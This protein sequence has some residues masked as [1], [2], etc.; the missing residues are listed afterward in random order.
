M[1]TKRYVV[2]RNMGISGSS[3]EYIVADLHNADIIAWFLMGDDK[4]PIERADQCA[5][6]MNTLEKV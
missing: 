4:P 1:K 3:Q 6:Y 2:L 5:K